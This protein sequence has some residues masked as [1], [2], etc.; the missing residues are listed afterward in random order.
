MDTDQIQ[1]IAILERVVHLDNPLS[2]SGRYNQ[3]SGPENI[4]LGPNMP[5]LTFA[6]HVR[7]P[8]LGIDNDQDQLLQRG[9]EGV[10]VSYLFH[11]IVLTSASLFHQGHNTKGA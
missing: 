2:A 11:R 10:G 8:Q 9:D 7:L 3:R 5:L 1:M 6:E 4:A